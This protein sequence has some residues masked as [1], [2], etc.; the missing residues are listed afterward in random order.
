MSLAQDNVAQMSIHQCPS[1]WRAQHSAQ[2][3]PFVRPSICGD[4]LWGQTHPCWQGSHPDLARTTVSPLR[5]LSALLYSSPKHSLLPAQGLATQ[6]QRASSDTTETHPE[7]QEVICHS[8]PF[9]SFPEHVSLMSSST[10]CLLLPTPSLLLCYSCH[11]SIPPTH[12]RGRQCSTRQ[13]RAREKL[14]SAVQFNAG[15]NWSTCILPICPVL[16]CAVFHCKQS[17]AVKHK[18]TTNLE[19]SCRKVVGK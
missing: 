8:C 12:L 7:V 18:C 11:S 2:H 14:V 17:A 1:M 9:P 6:G 3:H 16:I 5:P 4:S 10:S 19:A 15:G 13:P